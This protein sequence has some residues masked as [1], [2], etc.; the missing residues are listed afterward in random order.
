MKKFLTALLATVAITGPASAASL[1]DETQTFES[2]YV[3][4]FNHGAADKLTTMYT[5]DGTAV[6]QDG[7]ITTGQ[8]NLARLYSHIA[9]KLTLAIT[10]DRIHALGSGG[11]VL[12]HGSQ[13]L[14]DGDVVKTHGLQIFDRGER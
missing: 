13:T 8:A 2:E 12:I 9:G 5:S 14:P 3:A 10:I 6:A 7:S 11:W 4:A 1:K